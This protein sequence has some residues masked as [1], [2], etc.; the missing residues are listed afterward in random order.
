MVAYHLCF[1]CPF[2]GTLLGLVLKG[3]Q[4]DTSQF[5]GSISFLRQPHC[6]ESEVGGGLGKGC[7][8]GLG[9]G[10]VGGMIW[11]LVSRLLRGGDVSF[12]ESEPLSPP[13]HPA[14]GIPD[15]SP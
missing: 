12:S 2:E 11:F 3:N 4:K 1:F 10:E 8:W 5:G 9:G 13:R 7:C 14:P 15:S 6:C